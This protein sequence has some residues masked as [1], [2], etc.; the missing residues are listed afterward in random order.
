MA[1]TMYVLGK[2]G[3]TE[4]RWDGSDPNSVARARRVFDEFRRARALAFVVSGPGEEP[5]CTRDFEVEAQE[6]I[7][8]R[9]LVGG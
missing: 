7:L 1:G 4:L 9:P 5:V 8:T 3:D 2:R 6:I